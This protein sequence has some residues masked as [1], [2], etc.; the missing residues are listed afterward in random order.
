LSPFENQAWLEKKAI[1]YQLQEQN[2]KS[3]NKVIKPNR[4]EQP[5]NNHKN[6]EIILPQNGSSVLGSPLSF[7]G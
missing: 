4:K 6:G 1:R 3:R 2:I 7:Y 5:W